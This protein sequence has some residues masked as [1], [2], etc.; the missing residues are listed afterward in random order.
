MGAVPVAECVG[1]HGGVIASEGTIN[2]CDAR[3]VTRFAQ[4]RQT[5]R[6]PIPEHAAAANTVP[7]MATIA[8]QLEQRA[9]G[10]PQPGSYDPAAG[11]TPQPAYAILLTKPTP[12]I[13]PLA[14]SQE[15]GEQ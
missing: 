15:M 12:T 4:K 8:P 6:Q 14:R 7:P 3:A 10:D 5:A 11:S 2:A 1:F 9:H 13:S